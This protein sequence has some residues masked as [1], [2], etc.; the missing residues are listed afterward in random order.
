MKYVKHKVTE[1][2]PWVLECRP[3]ITCLILAK[4]EQTLV[5][6]RLL[7]D[8]L[9]IACK[10]TYETVNG[11]CAIAYCYSNCL[12]KHLY[13]H[14]H[15]ILSSI[16]ATLL[17]YFAKLTN[18]ISSLTHTSTNNH[19]RIKTLIPVLGQSRYDVYQAE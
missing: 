18:F 13:L 3:R 11:R 2:Q 4:V 5:P 15:I 9:H 7:K 17:Y 16:L 10:E 1:A 12:S 8:L 19:V 14:I 6:N